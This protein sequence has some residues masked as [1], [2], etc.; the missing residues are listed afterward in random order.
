MNNFTSNIAESLNSWLLVAQEMPILAMFKK[1]RQQLMTWFVE[2]R[3]IDKN[4][5]GILVKSVANTIQ[6]LQNDRS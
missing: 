1:I 6:V 5:T 2:R 4:N 3:E